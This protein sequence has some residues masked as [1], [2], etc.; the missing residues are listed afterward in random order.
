MPK[1]AEGNSCNC[2]SINCTNTWDSARMHSLKKT[3]FKGIRSCMK[4][5]HICSKFRKSRSYFKKL[6][7]KNEDKTPSKCIT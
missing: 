1:A 7:G 5:I 2:S 6:T 3:F 4:D